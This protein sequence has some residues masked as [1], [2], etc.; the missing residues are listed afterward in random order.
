MATGRILQE[1][2][3]NEPRTFSHLIRR[4][5]LLRPEK[6]AYASGEQVVT[7]REF[8]ARVNSLVE[9]LH[10]MGLRKG[11]VVGLLAWNSLGH[12]YVYG[13]AMKGGFIFSPFNPRLKTEELDY[14]IN[15]SE[16]RALFVGTELVE[17]ANEVRPRLHVAPECVALDGPEP[18][19]AI[20]ADLLAAEDAPEPDVAVTEDDPLH[21]I[22]TS[23]TTGQP[24]G[25]LYTH[26]QAWHD[27]QSLAVNLSVIPDD[28][29]LQ[30]SPLFHI[31]GNTF[32]RTF[33]FIGGRN[34][35]MSSFDAAQ[36][37]QAI[38]DHRV[39]HMFM[40]PTHLVMMLAVPDLDKY[41][42]TSVKVLWYGASVMP[43][44]TLEKG[45]QILGPVFGQGYGQTE[46]GPAISH[47]SR[48]EHAAFV[49]SA[50]DQ[51]KLRSVGQ[52]DPGVQIRIV[53]DRGEDVQVGEVGEIIVEEPPCDEWVLA[54]ARRYPRDAGRRLAA[55]RGHGAV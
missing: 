35:I 17:T 5:S 47:L 43:L 24:R 32:F 3:R 48:E 44:A 7:Y 2:A 15:Y 25:A 8:N 54:Q 39:T 4:H 37:L 11:D 46:S 55:H 34:T 33:L 22:Y 10:G 18:G 26:G 51:E 13:A 36:T 6:E 28:R 31:A 38:Q 40:V 1:V 30:I 45:L 49:D 19:M 20:M 41:D 9:A 52:A 42:L 16:C 12:A 50:V 29:H 21:I 14:L 23:G 53:G 27:C